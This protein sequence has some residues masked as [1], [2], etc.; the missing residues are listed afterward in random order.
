MMPWNGLTSRLF[1]KHEGPLLPITEEKKEEIENNN[2]PQSVNTQHSIENEKYPR[3]DSRNDEGPAPDQVHGLPEIK[4]TLA[5][6]EA[7]EPTEENTEYA[8]PADYE[9]ELAKSAPYRKPAAFNNPFGDN[10]HAL[11]HAQTTNPRR[12]SQWQAQRRTS[13]QP[14]LLQPAAQPIRNFSRP[15][16]PSID[17]KITWQPDPNRYPAD[18]RRRQSSWAQ[19]KPRRPS[20]WGRKVSTISTLSTQSE[21]PEIVDP[22]DPARKLSPRNLVTQRILFLGIVIILNLGCLMAALFSHSGT[23][24]FVFILVVKSKDVLSALVSPTGMLLRRIYHIFKPPKEVPSKWILSLIP[25]YSESEEQIVKCI[26]SLRDNGVEPHRQVMCVVLDGK[27][28][29]VK[30]HYTELLCTIERPYVS[31]K[32]QLGALR[33]HAGFMK[34]VPVIIIEKKKNAGKKDSLILAHDL[35]NFPRNNMPL[36]SELLRSEIWEHILPELTDQFP[37]EGFDMIFCTDADSVIH[38]GALASLT[39][40]LARK[41]NSIAACGLVLVELEPGYE[42]SLWNM[43]QQFQYCFGQYVRRRAEHFWGKVTC[44]P[45]CITM[46]KCRPECAG[47]IAKYAEAV[48]VMPVLHHQVQ[49]LGTD[50]RL[51]YC[52]LSQNR[53]LTTLFVPEAVSETVAPQSLQ[54]YLSQRRRWGS[55]A[56]FNN[57]FYMTGEKM[58]PIT[59]VAAF[60]EILRL[61]MVYYRFC[62]TILL[63]HHIIVG[64]INHT[65]ET[66]RL[67]PLLAVS[68]TPLLWFIISVMIEP[69]L[70]CRAHKL[71]MGFCINK[72]VSSFISMTVFW[73]VCRNVGSQVWGISG[74]TAA[75]GAAAAGAT[76]I[77]AAAVPAVPVVPAVPA[78]AVGI[79]KPPTAVIAP[80]K[81]DVVAPDL[82]R[83]S[84]NV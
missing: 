82:P 27:P 52:L 13:S 46:I 80:T 28:R 77:T 83:Q 81:E 45:G 63:V 20:E 76:A 56:Y 73:R 10:V 71:A 17:D 4:I 41:E 26:F 60:I 49:Y 8:A 51:T 54:H 9:K 21:Y 23:W 14:H 67:A 6:P 84:L 53:K 16:F 40:A 30:S 57:Y 11:P 7:E 44:L 33:I 50:R 65:F 19:D 12:A 35:F 61:S 69:Q 55:N 66:A 48:T 70:R 37:F 79:A 64:I 68:Q 75:S 62:N 34:D 39:N 2:A 31:F 25:A 72:C 58:S 24:V 15:S 3:K 59:R 38:Q 29:D 74:V 43:Y 18:Y 42:W 47:A 22:V 1:K 5:S 32:H 36:Y 78:A